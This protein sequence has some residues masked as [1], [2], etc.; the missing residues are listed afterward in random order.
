MLGFKK[1]KW[2]LKFWV[3]LL[4]AGAGLFF[5]WQWWGVSF[6]DYQIQRIAQKYKISFKY[7][8]L[9]S[10][11]PFDVSLE[12]IRW[13][14]TDFNISGE[15][16]RLEISLSLYSLL[17]GSLRP[18]RVKSGAILL[19][20]KTAQDA[21]VLK[22]RSKNTPA[23]KH[24]AASAIDFFY[25]KVSRFSPSKLY[26]WLNKIPQNLEFSSLEVRDQAQRQ[27]LVIRNVEPINDGLWGNATITGKNLIWRLSLSRQKAQL[28]FQC[29]DTLIW[30]FGEGRPLYYW[31]DSTVLL[32]QRLNKNYFTLQTRIRGGSFFYKKLHKNWVSCRELDLV[33][34]WKKVE[35]N[36]SLDT[37]SFLAVNR[38]PFQIRFRME[39]S[40]NIE[41]KL[42]SPML[43]AQQWLSALPQGMFET[44]QGLQLKGKLQYQLA[45]RY[46]PKKPE[47]FYFDSGFTARHLQLQKMGKVN[48]GLINGNFTYQP[49]HASYPR[50]VDENHNLTKLE[51]ISPFL[52]PAILTAEDPSFFQHKGFVMESIR[53]SILENLKAGYFRR[54]GSTISMQL[55]KNIY[56]TPEKTIGRK[57]E[58]IVLVWL[59]ENLNLVS[60]KRM[61][62]VY[63]SIIEWGP[64]VYGIQEASHFYFS[65]S[66]AQLSPEECIFLALIIPLPRYFHYQFDE[67]G[68]LRS[69]HSAFFKLVAN[70]MQN[71][72]GL[73][74]DC[75]AEIRPENVKLTGPA[76]RYLRSKASEDTEPIDIF[77]NEESD[78]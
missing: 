78:S 29:Q 30:Q 34:H 67:N 33:T 28:A 38:L 22:G 43:N 58:E 41:L 32:L 74:A 45:L 31:S 68:I 8:T 56:L 25:D 46:V 59:I 35:Q 15:I 47:L 24:T 10:I 11:T 54:G 49:I 60:K 1:P 6:I 26:N 70:K 77:E 61:L 52:A 44:L 21:S 12:N 2:I 16:D 64:G 5:S 48:L 7:G 20:Y 69:S 53:E 71:Q 66:P 39:G 37:G 19:F 73:A 18:E 17:S 36:W 72:L 27:A 3:L 42:Q 40:E 23:A 62:E 14:S 65:K 4:G 13:N 76:R 63:L 75:V 55:I 9:R 50:I 51:E 57:L